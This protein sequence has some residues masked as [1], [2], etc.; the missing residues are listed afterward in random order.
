MESFRAY[1][2]RE[3]DEGNFRGRIEDR[4]VDELPPGDVLIRV[5]YSSL[6][7]KDALSARGNRGVT[8]RYPHTPGIDAAGVVVEAEVDGFAPGDEVVV[9]GHD[10][11][12]NTWGGFSEYIRV[13]AG[14]VRS[15][16]PALSLEESMALG[17]AGFTAC[18]SV[19]KLVDHP[20]PAGSAVLVTGATGGVGSLTLGL[21]G[22][23]GFRPV[24]VTGK[25][26][27]SDFLRDLGAVEVLRR[28]D[29]MT[30]GG[31]PLGR[32]RWPAV[33]DTVGGPILGAVLKETGYRGAV[34]TCGMV[35]GSE[36]ET[37]VFPF[38]L[39]G[40]TLYGIDS[41]EC[42]DE[43]RPRI[44]EHLAGPWRIDGL[45]KR[46]RAVDLEGI[47]GE[48]ERMLG[49]RSRGRVLVRVSPAAE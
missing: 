37:S 2:V 28:S 40:V 33:V 17:T 8:K 21:L 12:M 16:E 7:Y 23:A 3:D 36:L 6:N 19:L 31:R 45:L 13:P 29:V 39:R 47:D 14:W 43:L 9:T 15:R 11:G 24:A 4:R 18:Q 34:T 5:R 42:P 44:W 46:V 10:L 32:A 48:I 38:I 49:G 27:Q 1:V 20:V 30:S 25:A 41:A 26:D 35:A 22:R